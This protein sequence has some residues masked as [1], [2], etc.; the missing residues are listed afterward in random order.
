MHSSSPSQRDGNVPPHCEAAGLVLLKQFGG[1]TLDRL[2]DP[3]LAV[4]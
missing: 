3:P 4:K 1:V 2:C